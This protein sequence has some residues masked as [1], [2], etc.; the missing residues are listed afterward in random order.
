MGGGKTLAE[1]ATVEEVDRL[2][3][4]PQ[5][6]L[7]PLGKGPVDL[8]QAFFFLCLIGINGYLYLVYDGAVFLVELGVDDGTDVSQSEA[9]L[10]A[11]FTYAV[12]YLVPL[13]H[14]ED[15]L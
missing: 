10:E 5:D 11:L 1:G 13:A 12:T 6:S 2:V 8:T 7:V 3:V 15:A 14:V 4:H 9:S